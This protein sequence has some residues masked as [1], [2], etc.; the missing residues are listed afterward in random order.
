MRTQQIRTFRRHA[1]GSLAATLLSATSVGAWADE[2]SP[3]YLG[4]SLGFTH[5][6]NVYR[7]PDGPGDNYWTTS[8][9]GGFDQP[10]GRQRLHATA[11]VGYNRY[12]DQSTLN[13]TSY[14]LN[15]GWDWATIEK[16]TGTVSVGAVQSLAQFNGNATQASTERN[17]LKVEQVNASARWGG[18]GL[19]SVFGDY[20]HTRIRYSSLQSLTSE[21]DGDSGSLGVN[22]RL[23]SQ[24]TVGAA[25]RLTRTDY[26]HGIAPVV[27]PGVPTPINP[28]DYQSDR[29]DGRN[30]DLLADW[31]YSAQTGV[32]ARLSWSRLTYANSNR[33]F[34]GL[35]GSILANYAPTAKLAFNASLSRDAGTNSSSTNY[36]N[37]ANGQQ[38]N[39]LTQSS[40]TT[41]SASVG[42][43]YA[44]TAKIS[45][46]A[47]LLYRQGDNGNGAGGDHFRIATLGVN[48][49]IAR[50][51]QLA[52]NASRE[53]RNASTLSYDANVFGCSAQFTLR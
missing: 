46:N 45:V 14:T 4:A 50:S 43:T 40:Q 11:Q 33:D 21:S 7:T 26:P 30:L 31:R 51:W 6:S 8:L 5:D 12:Q 16:L 15:A 52:C 18:D 32:S 42:A 25:V 10:I 2:P 41:D 9:L 38:I 35:T 28:A 22:Y 39:Y 17:I 23:G 27:L 53:S 48:Y 3:W 34:S 29:S 20:G 19:F 44:A 37:L 24:T 1:I 36:L 47:G 49:A 13:N